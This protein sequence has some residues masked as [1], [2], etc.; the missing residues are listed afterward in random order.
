MVMITPLMITNNDKDD[1]ITNNTNLPSIFTRLGKPI[2][3]SSNSWV[4]TKK[5]KCSNNV[6]ARF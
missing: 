5:K 6:Y 1:F 4:F 2:M 3:I